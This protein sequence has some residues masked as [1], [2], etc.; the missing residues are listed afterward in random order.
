[1]PLAISVDDFA[2]LNRVTTKTVREWIREGLPVI[3][4]GG[5][6]AGNGSVIDAA[7]GIPWV[8]RKRNEGLASMADFLNTRH[9]S[10]QNLLR[11]SVERY[12]E[13]AIRM[14]GAALSGWHRDCRSEWEKLGLT[15]D[16]MD[17]LVFRVFGAVALTLLSYKIKKFE[18]EVRELA[19]G[20]D[21][22]DLASL[23]LMGDF[24]TK[25]EDRIEIPETIKPYWLDRDV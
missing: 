18:G 23:Y 5:K 19:N 14:I 2:T 16:T 9:P 6:G 10:Q 24:Q 13:G 20:A 25:F 3:S 1:M 7:R 15:D 21:L 11:W 17:E 4:A 12:H 22:D 8:V